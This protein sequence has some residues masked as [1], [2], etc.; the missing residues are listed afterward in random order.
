L[1]GARGGG[2]SVGEKSAEQGKGKKKRRRSELV[3][4]G[5]SVGRKK[6]KIAGALG[7]GGE[8]VPLPGPPPLKPGKT[9][10]GV[11]AGSRPEKGGRKRGN[12]VFS[13]QNG[14]E[15]NIARGE[16]KHTS[17]FHGGKI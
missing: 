10:E 5:T 7:H 13:I 14:E 15:K 17:W 3:E 6:R 4:M 8:W 1:N 9:G 16:K 2:G 12:V 11:V